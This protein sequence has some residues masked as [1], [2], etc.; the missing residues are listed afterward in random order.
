MEIQRLKKR[1][2]ILKLKTD[3]VKTLRLIA[4]ERLSDN[5]IPMMYIILV[6]NFVA[7]TAQIMIVQSQPI[8]P[9]G[10]MECKGNEIILKR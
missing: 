2:Q 10:G 3:R 4:D 9:K 8:F 7:I 5:P 1:I 6:A